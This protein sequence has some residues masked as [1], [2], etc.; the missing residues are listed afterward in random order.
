MVKRQAE[1]RPDC[2]D[3]QPASA[4]G[5]G[6]FA[7]YFPSG[8]DPSAAEAVAAIDWQAYSHQQRKAQYLLVAR[9]ARHCRWEG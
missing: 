5:T 9:T 8:F 1:A 4:S 3:Q 2:I 7:V 6:P